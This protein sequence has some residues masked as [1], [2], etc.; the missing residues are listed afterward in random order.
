M[1]FKIRSKLKSEVYSPPS[2]RKFYGLNSH[3]RICS[4]GNFEASYFL[5]MY[6]TMEKRFSWFCKCHELADN[7]KVLPSKFLF[8]QLWS[9]NENF[10]IFTIF[11]LFKINTYKK[12]TTLIHAYQWLSPPE[13]FLLNANKNL[14]S[15]TE[16]N[17]INFLKNWTKKLH[18]R[19]KNFGWFATDQYKL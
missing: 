6:E 12:S 14:C 11:I 15:L 13:F 5:K 3:I 18:S 7:Y 19:N 9:I 10:T 17:E 2:T 8:Q 16:K 4:T 1:F